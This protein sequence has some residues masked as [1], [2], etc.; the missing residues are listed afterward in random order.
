V[1]KSTRRPAHPVALVRGG[2]ESRRESGAPE[3]IGVGES[4][5]SREITL[6]FKGGD[7]WGGRAA[8]TRLITSPSIEGLCQPQLENKHRYLGVLRRLGVSLDPV[9]YRTAYYARGTGMMHKRV[10][11]GDEVV[12]ATKNLVVALRHLAEPDGV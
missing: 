4:R 9:I 5:G 3:S 1:E 8:H 7:R 10:Q 2:G 12:N 6:V 11:L